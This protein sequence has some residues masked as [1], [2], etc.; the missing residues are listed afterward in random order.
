MWNL[1]IEKNYIPTESKHMITKH[2][3]DSPKEPER[4]GLGSNVSKWLDKIHTHT[5]SLQ[6]LIHL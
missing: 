6:S 4:W 3:G 1:V 2:I 5:L